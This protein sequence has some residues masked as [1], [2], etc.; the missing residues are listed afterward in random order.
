MPDLQ[1]EM[2]NWMKR[3]QGKAHPTHSSSRG[4]GS[5]RTEDSVGQSLLGPGYP[6]AGT[7]QPSSMG[8]QSMSPNK[9]DNYVD[10]NM[11]VPPIDRG[12]YGP[13]Y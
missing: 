11:D 6:N 5:Y 7:V 12:A 13:G 1:S 9:M 2:N 8:S 3:T 10:S 4:G